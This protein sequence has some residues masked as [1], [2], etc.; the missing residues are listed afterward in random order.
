MFK[1]KEI[2][3]SVSPWDS[4]HVLETSRNS[5]SIYLYMPVREDPMENRNVSMG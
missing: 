5:S 3:K 2:K 1:H 4:G